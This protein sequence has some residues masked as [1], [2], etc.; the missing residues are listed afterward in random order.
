MFLPINMKTTVLTSHR[1]MFASAHETSNRSSREFPPLFSASSLAH[2]W[3]ALHRAPH[4]APQCGRKRTNNF[5]GL[6]EVEHIHGLDQH[7][8]GL[9]GLS[10]LSVN[11]T[12]SVQDGRIVIAQLSAF[13]GVFDIAGFDFPGKKRVPC[14]QVKILSLGLSLVR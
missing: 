8:T 2:N 6:I 3:R 10:H 13:E 14:D 1:A 4:I 5:V 9:F 7:F 11:A 12:Q